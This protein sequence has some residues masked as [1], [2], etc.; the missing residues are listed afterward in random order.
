MVFPIRNVPFRSVPFRE[1]RR[2]YPLKPQRKTNRIFKQSDILASSSR[3]KAIAI[4]RCALTRI[5]DRVVI[6]GRLSCCSCLESKLKMSLFRF[7]F[8]PP[9]P[10]T[11]PATSEINE[12]DFC[13][14]LPTLSE[15]GLGVVEYQQVATAVNKELAAPP[16]KRK[17][18]SGTYTSYT[19]TQHAMI[20]KY[21]L[22]NDNERARKQVVWIS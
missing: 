13:S 19:P 7:G 20:G 16:A 14:T 17:R 9:T 15:S 4:D 11:S 21:A 10:T 3:V 1:I 8:R 5:R 6:V 2:A 22:E 18:G 12:A